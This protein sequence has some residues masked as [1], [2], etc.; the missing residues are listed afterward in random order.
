[1]F[2]P[3]NLWSLSRYAYHQ[4]WPLIPSFLKTINFLVF[5]AI[6][7]FDAEVGDDIKLQHYSLGVVIHPNVKIGSRVK[8]YHQVTLATET[9]IGS[10]YHIIIGDDVMIGTGAILIGR[11]DQDLVIGDRARIGANAVVTRDVPPDTTVVGIP[12]RPIKKAIVA[13]LPKY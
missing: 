5:H 12:A 7:P 10:P 1:M 9:W 3:E 4:K 6:L 8:I 2:C 11:G 13:Q